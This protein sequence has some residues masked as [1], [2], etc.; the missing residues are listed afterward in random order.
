MKIEAVMTPNVTSTPP[1]ATLAEASHRMRDLNVGVLPVV[2]GHRLVGLITDRDIIVRAG[3]NGWDLQ[4]K[5]VA[6]AMTA[7]V[8]CCAPAD[9]LETAVAKM[10][11]AQIRRLPVVDSQGGLVGVVSLG[12]IA[13]R[14]PHA[15]AGE[16]LAA[17][18]HHGEMARTG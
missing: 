10:A 13:L 7:P 14:A 15:L 3:A 9:S 8:T 18:S 17:I 2:E 16:A 6:D 1:K 12:D 11:A 5:T 4:T